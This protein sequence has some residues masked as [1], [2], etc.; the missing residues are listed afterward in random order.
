ME[1][2]GRK[3]P[4]HISK[5]QSLWVKA[6]LKNYGYE[7]TF[8]NA[9]YFFLPCE[10]LDKLKIPATR[11][12]IRLANALSHPLSRSP[13]NKIALTKTYVLMLVKQNSGFS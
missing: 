6:A 9:L 11:T 5:I 13:F 1:L 10:I 3:N 4:A 8:H 12:L 7:T 2:L